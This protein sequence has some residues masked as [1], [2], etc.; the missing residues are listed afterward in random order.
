MP[1]CVGVCL[2]VCVSECLLTFVILSF[3]LCSKVRAVMVPLK[4]YNKNIVKY[5]EAHKCEGSHV[6]NGRTIT[7]RKGKQITGREM[8]N[9]ENITAL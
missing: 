4:S 5:Y 1:G 7:R 3:I 8:I 6:L 2:C 9:N